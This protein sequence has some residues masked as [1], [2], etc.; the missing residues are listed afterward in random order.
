MEYI[1]SALVTLGVIFIFLGLINYLRLLKNSGNVFKIIKG[2][3]KKKK[4]LI[5]FAAMVSFLFLY[6]SHF[7]YLNL[8]KVMN[9][10]L[11]L[12]TSLLFF[13]DGFFIYIIILLLKNLSSSLNSF[14][15]QTIESLTRAVKL[16]DRYTGNHSEHVANLV[17]AIFEDL[18]SKLKKNLSKNDLVEAALLHDIGKIMTPSEILNK[19]SEL[20]AQEYE[21]IKKHVSDGIY[22]LEPFEVFHKIIPWIK[23]HHERI[24]GQGYYRLK[25]NEIP[26]ES[27]IIAVADTYSALTTSRIYQRKR[28]HREAVE[29]LK[30]ISGTQLDSGIVEILIK[31]ENKKMEKIFLKSGFNISQDEYYKVLAK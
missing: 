17:K 30:E 3:H 20:S 13:M 24:D 1:N 21:Q 27:R 28:S 25:K 18:P 2:S 4:T 7:G 11:T 26:L 19:K 23:Y 5:V 14:Y 15:T 8:K 31:I 10:Q 12:A 22:I 16:R 9:N 29:I 6:L